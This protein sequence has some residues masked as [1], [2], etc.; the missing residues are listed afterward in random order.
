LNAA[1]FRDFSALA[2]A[3]LLEPCHL[4]YL[5]SKSYGRGSEYLPEKIAVPLKFMS[6]RVRNGQPLLDYAYGYGPY[7]WRFA[8]DPTPGSSDYTNE[9]LL[10]EDG[11]SIT[12]HLKVI[13]KF[14][15][16]EDEAGFILVHIAIGSK[17]N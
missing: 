10:P 8:V 12:K 4:E 14:N 15:G 1:L 7:N 17:S 5:R 13:R 3:Y 16:C 2:A 9:M 11:V 6:D